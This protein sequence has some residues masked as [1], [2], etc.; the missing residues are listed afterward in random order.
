[1]PLEI[2]RKFL[3]QDER[4]RFL[5]VGKIY[6]QGY[7][8]TQTEGKTVRVRIAGNQGY[9]TIKGKSQGFARLEFEYPIPHADAEI[10]LNTLCDRPLIEKTRYQI[11]YEGL[12]WEVDEFMGENEGLILAEVE[13]Q[14]AT[15]VISLPPWIGKEVTQDSRYYNSN[16]ANCPYRT[17]SNPHE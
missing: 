4:W 1:M 3:V 17:W 13:L 2:E 7:I 16:L 14:E 10:L 5:G 11:H 6:R 15:Q 9:L 12:I 8:K